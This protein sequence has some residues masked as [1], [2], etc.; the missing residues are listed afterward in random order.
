MC[1]M[2]FQELGARALQGF[3]L[4]TAKPNP[5]RR[6]SPA[7]RPPRGGRRPG[8]R[9]PGACVRAVGGGQATAGRERAS[10]RWRR[11]VRSCGS[12]LVD[13]SS[14]V[15]LRLLAGRSLPMVT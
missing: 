3:L 12:K 6:F 5:S 15:S 8:D 1:Q 9:G 11:P 14:V 10:A 7:S 13:G 2:P 4:P